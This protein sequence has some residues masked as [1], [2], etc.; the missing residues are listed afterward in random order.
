MILQ[1]LMKYA[2]REG[3]GDADFET[4]GLRWFVSI[5]RIG[6]L[7]GPHVDLASDGLDGGRLR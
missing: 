7:S 1:A 5:S 4:V 6:T 3:I 2:E